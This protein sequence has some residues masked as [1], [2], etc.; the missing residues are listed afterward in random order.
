MAYAI[1]CALVPLPEPEKPEKSWKE[2]VY[3]K[4]LAPLVSHQLV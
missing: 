2:E 4:Q 3:I 1:F